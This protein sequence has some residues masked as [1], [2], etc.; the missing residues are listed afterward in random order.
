MVVQITASVELAGVIAAQVVTM[1]SDGAG[2]VYASVVVDDAVLK[3]RRRP[4]RG[5]DAAAGA[6]MGA[7][8]ADGAVVDCQYAAVGDATAVVA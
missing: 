6:A 5:V 3:S 1:R 8:S 7:I 2:T 4:I